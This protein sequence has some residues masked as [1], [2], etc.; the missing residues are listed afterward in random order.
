MHYAILGKS[1]ATIN[2][3]VHAGSDP[4]IALRNGVNGHQFARKFGDDQIVDILSKENV[5]KRS[6]A[7]LFQPNIAVIT[8]KFSMFVTFFMLNDLFTFPAM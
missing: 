6:L 7:G 2:E 5:S 8:S 4:L 3:L 1:Y